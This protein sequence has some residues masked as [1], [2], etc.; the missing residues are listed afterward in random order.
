MEKLKGKQQADGMLDTYHIAWV[1]FNG[2]IVKLDK[3][4]TAWEHKSALF[5]AYLINRRQPEQTIRTYTSGIKSTLC[6]IAIS[7]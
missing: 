2:F 5:I 7:L 6:E 4:P 1:S 3:K